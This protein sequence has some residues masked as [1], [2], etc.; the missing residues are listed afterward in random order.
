MKQLTFKKISGYVVLAGGIVGV[1]WQV[2][3]T[4]LRVATVPEKLDKQTIKVEQVANEVAEI[5]GEL[6]T[7]KQLIQSRMFSLSVGTNN[8][9]IPE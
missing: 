8:W 9:Q 6:R 5:R 7:V 4:V 3:P 1:V 2:T